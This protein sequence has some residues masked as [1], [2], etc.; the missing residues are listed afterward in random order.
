MAPCQEAKVIIS[1]SLFDLLCNN[2]ML[3]ALIRITS[4]THII[5]FRDKKISLNICFLELSEEFGRDSK[6]SSN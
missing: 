2:G 4:W 5:Q 6:T 3:C 1:G